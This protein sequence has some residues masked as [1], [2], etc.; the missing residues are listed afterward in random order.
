MSCEVKESNHFTLRRIRSG[1]IAVTNE[2][3]MPRENTRSGGMIVGLSSKHR[4]ILEYSREDRKRWRSVFAHTEHVSTRRDSEYAEE[5]HTEHTTPRI[6]YF[7]HILKVRYTAGISVYRDSLCGNLYLI[8][9]F[10]I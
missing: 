9:I 7:D 3:D 2:I 5:T 1:S 4:G 8:M 6:A 10:H